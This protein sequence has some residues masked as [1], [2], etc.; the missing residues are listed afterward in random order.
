MTAVGRIPPEYWNFVGKFLPSIYHTYGFSRGMPVYDE[1]QNK[2]MGLLSDVV[3]VVSNV[4]IVTMNIGF[5]K[6]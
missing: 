4:E 6:I 1:V 3:S 2:M 5:L